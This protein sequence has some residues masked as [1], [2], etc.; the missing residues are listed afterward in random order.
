MTPGGDRD[1]F[2]VGYLLWRGFDGGN[3]ESRRSPRSTKRFIN[4]IAQL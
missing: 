4:D 1:I 3:K 2:I